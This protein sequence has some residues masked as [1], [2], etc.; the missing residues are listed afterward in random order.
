MPSIVPVLALIALLQQP[1]TP[2]APADTTVPTVVEC[3]GRCPAGVTA[4]SFISFP[5]LVISASNAGV[6][7]ADR[8]SRTFLLL[9]GVVGPGGNVEME[10]LQMTGGTARGMEAEM[11]RG[12]AQARFK[13]A[14]RGAEPI[15]ARVT[16][17]FE[18]EAEGTSWVKYTYRVTAR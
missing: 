3:T 18:F 13:P 1:A 14:L 16:F 9:Q 12:L 11:R 10:S 4:P 5:N 15:R 6:E 7:L 8:R 17:R 2:P